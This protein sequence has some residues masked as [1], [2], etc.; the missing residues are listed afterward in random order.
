M[1]RRSVFV[2]GSAVLNP[3]V[4]DMGFCAGNPEQRLDLVAGTKDAVMMVRSG[5]YKALR[6]RCSARSSSATSRCSQSST[7]SSTS[8][9]WRPKALRRRPRLPPRSDKGEGRQ[10]AAGDAHRLRGPRQ[11]PCL[12]GRG[13]CKAVILRPQGGSPTRTLVAVIKTL[14][15][16]VVAGTSSAPAARIGRTTSSQCARSRRRSACCRAPT[17]RRSSP[18]ARP[19]RWS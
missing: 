7:S 5:A 13:R 11:A 1:P 10:R 8:P 14:Q 15:I 16:D 2:D 12:T 6:G 17:A 18:A 3:A 4:D 19:G 9:G